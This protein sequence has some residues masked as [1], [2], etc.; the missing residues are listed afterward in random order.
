MGKLFNWD[1][2]EGEDCHLMFKKFYVRTRSLEHNKCRVNICR[3]SFI[4]FVVKRVKS[5][6]I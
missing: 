4:N 5:G 3:L 2:G 6:V 1:D